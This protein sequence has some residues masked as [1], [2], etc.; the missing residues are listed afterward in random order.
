MRST[1]PRGWNRESGEIGSFP[2]QGFW[3]LS[4][5]LF[6]VVVKIPD[7][8]LADDFSVIVQYVEQVI[9]FRPEAVKDDCSLVAATLTMRFAG[10]TGGVTADTANF[11]E[12]AIGLVDEMVALHHQRV[13]KREVAMQKDLLVGRKFEHQIHDL[14]WFVNVQ[15]RKDEMIEIAEFVPVDIAI[16]DRIGLVTYTSVVAIVRPSALCGLLVTRC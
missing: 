16:V 7:G 2:C 1:I 15:H 6:E 13:G 4:P 12:G 3:R 14:L 10:R 9:V 5:P 8:Q 11:F